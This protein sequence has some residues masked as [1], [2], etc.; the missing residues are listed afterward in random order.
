MR[1]DGDISQFAV[2]IHLSVKIHLE[3]N[4]L[5]DF[6]LF[7][8]PC[9]PVLKGNLLRQD[10]CITQKMWHAFDAKLPCT[11]IELHRV[12]WS[13]AWFISLIL[14]AFIQSISA[15]S[16]EDGWHELSDVVVFWA[17][18]TVCLIEATPHNIVYF[19]DIKVAL[20]ETFKDVWISQ[21]ISIEFFLE[22]VVD[23][24][25]LV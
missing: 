15:L 22:H 12:E 2:V 25:L 6:T 10:K 24:K 9:L 1:L 17:E 11:S 19:I 13:A 3:G 5:N 8:D 23:V 16:H 7:L 4:V 20:V 14:W 21:G 18:A